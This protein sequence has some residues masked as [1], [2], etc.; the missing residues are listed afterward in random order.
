MRCVGVDIGGTSTKAAIVDGDGSVLFTHSL[1]T[2]QGA[3]GVIATAI[4]AIEFVLNTAGLALADVAVIGVGIP[5]AVDPVTGTVR[6]AV[7][8]SIGAEPV[9]LGAALFAHFGRPVHVENDVKAAALGAHFMTA[10]SGDLAYLS[11]GTGIAAGFV[12]QGRL[13]RGSSLVAG[14]IGHIPIDPA[15]PV[16]A[17]GQTGCIEAIA[18]G[19]AIERDWPSTNGSSAQ[20][21]VSAA[22]DGDESAAAVWARVVTGLSRAVQLLALTLDPDVIVLSGG[23]ADLGDVLKAAIVDRLADD[24]QRSEFLHSLDLGRRIQ[25][26]DPSVLLGPIGAVRAASGAMAG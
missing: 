12:E 23:V 16:C 25:V 21:L 1:P 8:V 19:S 5:G 4:E 22:S 26:I 3:D 14:E 18:S 2:Q 24:H 13:R 6:H 9:E 15:G 17:C 20:S 11:I 7:N 10:T